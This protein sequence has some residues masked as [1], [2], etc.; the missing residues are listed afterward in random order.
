M[1]YYLLIQNEAVVVEKFL[2][3]YKN[4]KK[5]KVNSLKN[6]IFE[7]LSDCLG[8]KN[9][10]SVDSKGFISSMSNLLITN[11]ILFIQQKYKSCQKLKYNV[12]QIYYGKEYRLFKTENSKIV[13]F[14]NQ[15]FTDLEEFSYLLNWFCDL[16]YFVDYDG[17]IFATNKL[18]HIFI[19]ANNLTSEY[20]DL[21]YMYIADSFEKFSDFRRCDELIKIDF[22][23]LDSASFENLCYDFLEASG[24]QNIHPIGNSNASDGGRDLLAEEIITGLAGIEKRAYVIQCKHRKTTSLSRENVLE[25]ETLLRE[26]NAEKYLLICSND[27]TPQTI[28]RLEKQNKR[29]TNK[30]VYWGK[31]EFAARLQKFPILINKYKL[32]GKPKS[33]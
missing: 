10:K 15:F 6:A 33:N 17:N 12:S 31:I 25:I 19:Q 23:H 18:I 4:C 1:I 21:E 30:V 16:D 28:D 13:A 26:N 32:F 2:E 8:S 24:F 20:I 9:Y 22:S 29:R 3:L 5:Y 27:L 7:M 14:N 11:D